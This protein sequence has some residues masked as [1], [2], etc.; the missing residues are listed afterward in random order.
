MRGRGSGVLSYTTQVTLHLSR[1]IDFA[2]W[3]LGVFTLAKI[4]VRVVWSCFFY[5]L[6]ESSTS[7]PKNVSDSKF[8][9]VSIVTDRSILSD[10][11]AE[12]CAKLPIYR[13]KKAQTLR[14]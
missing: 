9:A 5:S 3:T 6:Q 8:D 12:M 2:G 1:Y 13:I 14:K 10:E 11:M 4:K 7:T